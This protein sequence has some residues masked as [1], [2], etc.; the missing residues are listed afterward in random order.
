[1]KIASPRQDAPQS[2]H[3]TAQSNTTPG[4]KWG[5]THFEL[6]HSFFASLGIPL[7]A[8][9]KLYKAQVWPI[10]IRGE[11]K[12]SQKKILMHSKNQVLPN[13]PI[14]IRITLKK[15]SPSTQPWGN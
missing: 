12:N 9:A 5:Q 11:K 1:V 4:G 3:H 13:L 2:P 7:S 10:L 14:G 8:N 6:H 15:T